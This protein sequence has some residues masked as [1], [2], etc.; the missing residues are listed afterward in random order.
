ML[1]SGTFYNPIA[2]V[3]SVIGEKVLLVHAEDDKICPAKPVRTFAKTTGSKLKMY[4]RG[5]H[6]NFDL[7]KGIAYNQILKFIQS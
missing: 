7:T 1:G 6:A 5:G 2:E 4:K 3:E